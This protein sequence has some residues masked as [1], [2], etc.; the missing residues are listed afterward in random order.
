MNNPDNLKK[1]MKNIK[2]EPNDR[3]KRWVTRLLNGSDFSREKAAETEVVSIIRKW[4]KAVVMF[5]QETAKQ[6]E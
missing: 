4:A 1:L 2:K 6:P 3:A 5:R